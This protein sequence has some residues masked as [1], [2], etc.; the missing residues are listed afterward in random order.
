MPTV[1]EVWRI[2]ELIAANEPVY[3]EWWCIW[4]N[5]ER[6]RQHDSYPYWDG[7]PYPIPHAPECPYRQVVE[8]LNTAAQEP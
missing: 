5:G 8:L 2:L 1:A 6:P 4:C 7:E 3:D